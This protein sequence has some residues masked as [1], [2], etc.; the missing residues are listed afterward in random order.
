MGA[1]S[2]KSHSSSGVPAVPLESLDILLAIWAIRDRRRPQDALR[3][4]SLLAQTNHANLEAF[5]QFLASILHVTVAAATDGPEGGEAQAGGCGVGRLLCAYVHAQCMEQA[6]PRGDAADEHA[7][8]TRA[9]APL[10]RGIGLPTVHY[11]EGPCRRAMLLSPTRKYNKKTLHETGNV[12]RH[13]ATDVPPR[14]QPRCLSQGYTVS[15]AGAFAYRYGLEAMR[16]ARSLSLD[17]MAYWVKRRR[18]NM[19]HGWRDEEINRMVYMIDDIK[20]VK[21]WDA[22]A[23]QLFEAHEGS[24]EG[25]ERTRTILNRDGRVIYTLQQNIPT[26]PRAGGDRISNHTYTDVVLAD[27]LVTRAFLQTRSWSTWRAFRDTLPVGTELS[28]HSEHKLDNVRYRAVDGEWD[29]LRCFAWFVSV[30]I[31]STR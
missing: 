28:V 11:R 7:E 4:L 16:W 30:P 21:S 18:D 14:F 22:T 23:K 1:P 15:S 19:K 5:L 12:F 3:C 25:C 29:R 20:R 24:R 17:D 8:L 26:L 2:I 6:M 9:V 27:G 31:Q 10:L 13:V